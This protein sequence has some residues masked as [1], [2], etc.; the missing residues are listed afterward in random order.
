M[1]RTAVRRA[2]HAQCNDTRHAAHAGVAGTRPGILSRKARSCRC[3]AHF[4]HSKRHILRVFT[5]KTTGNRQRPYPA[6]RVHADILSREDR[7]IL[8]SWAKQAKTSNSIPCRYPI[9]QK[10]AATLRH[11][12][13]LLGQF[14]TDSAAYLP[15]CAASPTRRLTPPST[16]TLTS[17]RATA[18]TRNEVANFPKRPGAS[19]PATVPS[20]AGT[21]VQQRMK[22]AGICRYCDGAH[23]VL[24]RRARRPSPAPARKRYLTFLSPDLGCTLSF[25]THGIDQAARFFRQCRLT[26]GFIS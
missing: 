3:F 23:A 13:T 21:R 15:A 16:S 5:T 20:A 6:T 25:L 12:S 18:M 4:R 7:I 14:W 17:A 8:Q 2:A 26:A 11:N 9:S 24:A 10:F 19:I 22:Q 1:H